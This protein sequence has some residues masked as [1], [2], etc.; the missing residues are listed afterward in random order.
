MKIAIA[1][2]KGGTGKTTLATNLACFLGKHR[3]VVLVDLDVEEPNSGIFIK[4]DHV[5]GE[6]KFKMIPIWQGKC[7][8]CG[9][10][11][12]VCNFNAILQLANELVI[13]PNLCHSCYACSELCPDLAI[14]MAPQKIGELRHSKNNRLSFVEGR[15]DIGQEHATPLIAQIKKYVSDH[16]SNDFIQ[17]YDAPPGNSCPVIEAIKNVDLIFLVTEPT[18]FGLHDL[19]LAVE[20]VRKLNKS[21]GIVINRE[22]IGNNEVLEYCRQEHLPIL[23]KIPDNRHIAELYSRG[24]LVYHAIPEVAQQLFHIEQYLNDYLNEGHP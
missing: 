23:A 1:S 24:E 22:G 11:Q 18:P 3:N 13:F 6:D 14:P 7:S 19:K 21:F 4:G 10:C 16:F 20:I 15:L 5:C 12:E 8:L 17:I 9:L 2:G